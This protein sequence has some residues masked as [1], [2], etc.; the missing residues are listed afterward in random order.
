MSPT[1]FSIVLVG[2]FCHAVWNAIVKAAP[3][4]TLTAIL[5]AAFAGALAAVALPFLP[6][7]SPASWPYLVTS[8]ILQTGYYFLVAGAYRAADMSQAYPLMRGTAPLIVATVTAFWLG[9]HLPPAAW[10]GIALIS[11]GV[12]G[13]SLT[14][15]NL[16]SRK[17]IAIALGN[18]V[19]IAAYTIA[20]GLGVRQSGSPAGYTAWLFLI[21]AFPLVAWQ[22]RAAPAAF[23][24]YPPLS[25]A[26]AAVGGAA[27]V[28]SYGLALWAMTMAPVAVVAALRETSILFALVIAFFVLKER[29]TPARAAAAAVVVVGAIML[30]LA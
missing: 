30:R 11:G 12:V 1:V 24:A 28:V 22:L 29:V 4:K 14:G 27:S 19:V 23:R 16:G 8:V 26:I 25:L 3:D 21:T 2:A 9:E 5:M 10:L 20:D 13:V 18:A 15:W 6:S 17:G 7:P